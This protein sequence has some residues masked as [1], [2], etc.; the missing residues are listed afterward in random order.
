M[1]PLPKKT[2][3]EDAAIERVSILLEDLLL[4][5]EEQEA[6]EKDL[7]WGEVRSHRYCLSIGIG[8]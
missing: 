2:K 8:N 3:P 1:A 6:V 7:G 5:Q 4:A